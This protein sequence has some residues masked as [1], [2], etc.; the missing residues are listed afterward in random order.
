MSSDGNLPEIEV[1][2]KRYVGGKSRNIWLRQDL[3]GRVAGHGFGKV[4]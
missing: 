1:T 4:G 2:F 3:A